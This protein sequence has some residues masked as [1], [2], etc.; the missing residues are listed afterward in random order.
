MTKT[1]YYERMA[2]SLGD[3]ARILEHLPLPVDPIG[4]ARKKVLDVGCGGG[5]FMNFLREEGYDVYGVDA[6]G[7][8]KEHTDAMGLPVLSIYAHE[9]SD[10]FPSEFFDVIICSSVFHEVFSYGTPEIGVGKIASLDKTMEALTFALKRGGTLIIR[11]G[12]M[13]DDNSIKSMVV[14]DVNAVRKFVQCSPFNFRSYDR[15]IQIIPAFDRDNP[16][17]FLGTP[18]SLME[19]AF[20]Y[21]WGDEAFDREVQEF[22]G[23][24]TRQE[25]IEYIQ[26]FGY[27]PTYSRSYVQNGYPLYLQGKVKF[28]FDFPASNAL[29]VYTKD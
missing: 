23:L 29:W 12:V 28:D 8:S 18:S 15:T 17:R 21:T 10:F 11:D 22:Y 24:F 5:E 2:S 25:Y 26:P 13:P 16:H 20:T 3:K 4:S 27:S 9:V 7:E 19:F 14:E 1:L 6:D